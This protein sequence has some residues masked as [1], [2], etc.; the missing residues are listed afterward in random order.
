MQIFGMIVEGTVCNPLKYIYTRQLYIS[1]KHTCNSITY[2][3]FRYFLPVETNTYTILICNLKI[4]N[5]PAKC[6]FDVRWCHHIGFL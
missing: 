1:A 6:S 3:F 2:C 5:K 4:K